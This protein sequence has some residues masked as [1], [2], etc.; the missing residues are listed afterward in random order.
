MKLRESLRLLL[1]LALLIGC[2]KKDTSGDTKTEKYPNSNS[3]QSAAPFST[4]SVAIAAPPEEEKRVT[5]T[6]KF[7]APISL[8]ELENE[9]TGPFKAQVRV[10]FSSLTG[11]LAGQSA[12]LLQLY[13]DS[14][15]L[16]FLIKG[17]YDGLSDPGFSVVALRN[18]TQLNNTAVTFP[19]TAE[20]DLQ[21]VQ[22]TQFLEF[23]ARIPPDLGGSGAWT[24]VAVAFHPAATAPR[25]RLMIGISDVDKK[26]KFYFTDF[27]LEGD[28]IGGTVEGPILVKVKSSDDAVRSAQAKLVLD[29]PDMAG[30]LTD[31]DAALMASTDAQTLL[32]AAIAGATLQPATLGD[33]AAKMLL[34]AHKSLQKTRDVAATLE[35]TKAKSAAKGLVRVLGNQEGA[36]GNLLGSKVPS[37][38][39]K[40]DIYTWHAD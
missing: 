27:R 18:E 36:M 19:A 33:R 38:S 15:G 4:A 3:S 7:F 30:S 17:R 6:A 10:A 37:L 24:P 2:R 39:S 16:R 31:L 28:G 8:T 20:L 12:A 14:T 1:L 23:S 11:L 22:A 26:G 9:S 40:P 25:F 5:I 29:P 32:T 21:I 35:V 34:S 13:E